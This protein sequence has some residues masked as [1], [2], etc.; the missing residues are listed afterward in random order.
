MEPAGAA[1][2]EGRNY[3]SGRVSWEEQNEIV[4]H[5]RIVGLHRGS[6]VRIVW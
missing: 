5:R 6:C 1:V 3:S 2:R 4:Q